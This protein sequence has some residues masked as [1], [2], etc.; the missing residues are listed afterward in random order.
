VEEL[1]P[2]ERAVFPEVSGQ[3]P[4]ASVQQ[5]VAGSW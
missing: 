2:G 4:A 3:P 1:H 5:L